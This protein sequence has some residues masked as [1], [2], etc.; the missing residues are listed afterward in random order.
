MS[1]TA[2]GLDQVTDKQ[3]T[4]KDNYDQATAASDSISQ[5]VGG[6][7]LFYSS[8]QRLNERDL[9]KICV[10]N[11]IYLSKALGHD[12]NQEGGTGLQTLE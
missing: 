11:P 5:R 1:S 12:A 8:K 3:I 2:Y 10:E 7:K 9:L 6:S 4:L